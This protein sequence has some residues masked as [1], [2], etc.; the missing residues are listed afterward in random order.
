MIREATAFLLDVLK[1]NLPEHGAL[2]T[3]VNIQCQK[4]NV[5]KPKCSKLMILSYV[6][7][8]MC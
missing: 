7:V 2:Q 4:S 1:P 5:Q 3:K 6:M 8:V